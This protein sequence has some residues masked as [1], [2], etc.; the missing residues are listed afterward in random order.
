MRNANENKQ[1]YSVV[2]ALSCFL[3]LFNEK[4]RKRVKDIT[5]YTLSLYISAKDSV[6]SALIW[7]A[8][9]L[10]PG[11]SRETYQQRSHTCQQEELCLRL[12]GM[13][14]GGKT[15]QGSIHVGRAHETAYG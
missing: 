6:L 2:V 5:R 15:L 7:Y 9:P 3:K 12:G 14:E 8:S 4:G 11:R 1:F 10:K 13:L